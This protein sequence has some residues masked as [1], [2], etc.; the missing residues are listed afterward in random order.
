MHKTEMRNEKTM[1]IDKAST[2]EMISLLHNENY[3]AVR[4]IDAAL[5]EIERAVDM[6]A[7]RMTKGGRLIY[8]GAGTSGRL[9]KSI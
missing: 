1:H 4:A 6:I 9:G 8:M 7:D 3:N 2:S 5:P